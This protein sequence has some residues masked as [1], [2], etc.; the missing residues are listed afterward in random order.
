MLKFHQFPLFVNLTILEHYHAVGSHAGT[1]NIMGDNDGGG[2]V[3]FLDT[4]N[5]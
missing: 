2:L 5:E 1:F 4:I 3:F